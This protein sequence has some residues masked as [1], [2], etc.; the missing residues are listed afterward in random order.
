M[1]VWDIDPDTGFSSILLDEKLYIGKNKYILIYNMLYKT[2]TDANS[3]RIR[4]NKINGFIKI[5]NKIRYVV[6]FDD[7]CD[8][9]CYSIEYLISEK[10][11]ITDIINHNFVRIKIDSYNHLPIEKETV[12]S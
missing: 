2:S 6:L 9:I 5:H 10:S 4:C 7:W 8:N 3:L 1:R 11:G 12:S